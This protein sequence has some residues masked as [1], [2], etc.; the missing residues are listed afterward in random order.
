[1][2]ILVT[3]ANGQLGNELRTI[4]HNSLDKYIFTDINKSQPDTV[5]LDITDTN[6]VRDIV[7]RKRIDIIVNCAAYTNVN[8]AETDKDLAEKLNGK[9]PQILASAI[10]SVN[11]LLIHISTDYVYDGQRSTPYKENM[12]TLPLNAYGR[13][14]L[15]G[16]R[17]IEEIGV[18]HVILRTAWL[19]S[20]YG[21]N[22]V[23][24][25]VEKLRQSQ[26]IETVT[27]VNDQIG[28]PTYAPDLAD[29]IIDIVNDKD[30]HGVLHCSNEGCC[31]WYDLTMAI[32]IMIGSESKVR[33]CTSAYIQSKAKRPSYSV[34]DKT[35]LLMATG[36]TMPHWI[37][38]LKYFVDN[39]L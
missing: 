13:T 14:K 24:T 39:D 23:K 19:Y 30:I 7:S 37:E 36:K 3:G 1:M 18:D 21:K 4:A 38:S 8:R 27:V 17:A 15:E 11:G 20:K 9:A 34:M 26:S 16:E 22:F 12:L 6:A 33:P 35:S 25:M 2:N 31:S 10:K 5:V 32:K 29:I 28:S